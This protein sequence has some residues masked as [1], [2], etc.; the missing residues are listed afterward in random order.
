MQSAQ[1]KQYLPLGTCTVLEH[2]ISRLLQHPRIAGV[3]L[4]IT[5][6]DPYWADLAQGFDPVRVKVAPGGAERCHSVLNALELLS[7]HETEDAWVLVHD[8]ARP[9]LRHADID[10]LFAE[11]EQHQVGGILALPVSDTV[12]R[13]GPDHTISATVDR[14]GLWRA[15]TPQM[16]RLGA[17]RRSIADA[18]ARGEL[19]TDEAAAIEAAGLAP[20]V[21]EGHADNIKITRPGDLALAALYLDLQSSKA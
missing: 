20:K 7:R 3:V 8:A 11:L 17:L 13:A 21:V 19:V 5:P 10:R 14:N 16:F 1:P 12:K 15:M 2:T 9:C 18:L 6:G 4:A